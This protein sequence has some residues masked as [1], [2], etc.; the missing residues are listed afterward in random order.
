MVKFKESSLKGVWIINASKFEDYRGEYVE[1]YNKE[2]YDR[3]MLPENQQ[4]VED[5][6]SITYKNCFKGIHGDDR[7]YKLIS[8]L[9]GVF[10]LV[11]LNNNK[12]SAEYGKHISFTLSDKNRTQILVPPKFGNGHLAI[13][14]MSIF[15][16]KQTSY[17]EP[18][19]QFTIR[20]N[21]PQF[22]IRLPIK[23]P[24]LSERDEVGNFV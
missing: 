24:I 11:V 22:K 23:D 14:D 21:D 18:S 6:I 9:Y 1:I 2:M 4:F 7:T 5:D 17:Y 20:W 19:R 10:Y 3:R 8:C 16:Y 15:H 12:D 13:S